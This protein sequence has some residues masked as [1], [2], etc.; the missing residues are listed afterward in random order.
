MDQIK[1]GKFIAERRKEKKLTQAQLAEML[2]ITD[3]AISKWETGRSLPDSAIML[4]LCD[5]LGITVNELL[6]GEE[7]KMENKNEKLEETLLQMVKEKEQSDRWLLR[8]EIIIG[9]VIIAM[10]LGLCFIAA[11]AEIE[12]WLRIVLVAGGAIPLL[13]AIPFLLRIEQKA[14]YYECAKCGHKYVPTFKAINLSMHMGRTRY[15]RCPECG[16]IS[17]QKKRISK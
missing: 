1:T 2:N 6:C 17:W 7:I 11:Y 3:R 16:K 8:V 4:E 12:E 13:I 5:I 15:M 14:G 9:T 10:F